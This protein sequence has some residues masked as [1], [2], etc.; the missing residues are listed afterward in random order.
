[1]FKFKLTE[2]GHVFYYLA[3]RMVKDVFVFVE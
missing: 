1:M 2:Q 3:K